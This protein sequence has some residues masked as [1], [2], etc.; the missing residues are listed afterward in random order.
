MNNKE[1]EVR[2]LNIDKDKLVAKILSLG[3]EDKGEF[4]LSETIFYDP[5]LS[6]LK[7][8]RFVRLRKTNKGIKLT[9]KENKEQKIDSAFEIEF[10]VSDEEQAKLFL[11]KMGL[12]SYRQQEKKRHTL[13]LNDITFDIDTWPNIP[14]YIEIEGPDEDSLKEIVKIID[15]GWKDGVFEDAKSIIENHYNISFGKMR[16]FTFSRVE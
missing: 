5:E 4:I 6:W 13:L 12:I 2:F 1:I 16:Y 8:G 14:S 15:L 3:G 10:E 11:E 9:Y 7:E